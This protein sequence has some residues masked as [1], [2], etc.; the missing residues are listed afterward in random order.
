[1]YSKKKVKTPESP[2]KRAGRKDKMLSTILKMDNDRSIGAEGIHV[3]LYSIFNPE[4]EQAKAFVH[5]ETQT[6][7]SFSDRIET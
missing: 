5:E 6:S 2:K 4:S 7:L 3:K 1:M